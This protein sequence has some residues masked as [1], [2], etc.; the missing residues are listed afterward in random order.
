MGW[1]TRSDSTYLLHVH[2]NKLLLQKMYVLRDKVHKNKRNLLHF[3]LAS[4]QG[5]KVELWDVIM[6]YFR[7]EVIIIRQ[8]DI[9]LSF[10]HFL[11][12]QQL[13]RLKMVK[14]SMDIR[15]YSKVRHNIFDDPSAN[16]SF[17]PLL[18]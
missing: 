16:I 11:S 17:E 2:T 15:P 6:L 3:P 18:S 8:S 10:H 5:G 4:T 1:K 7:L 9:S 14:I 13:K 12:N